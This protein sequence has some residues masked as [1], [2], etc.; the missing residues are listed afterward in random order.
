MLKITVLFTWPKSSIKLYSPWNPF[1]PLSTLF[2]PF[3]SSYFMATAT[4]CNI[5]HFLVM[6]SLIE[7]TCSFCCS[8][9]RQ[10]WRRITPKSSMTHSPGLLRD[11]KVLTSL[12]SN[13]SLSRPFGISRCLKCPYLG[14][15]CCV[16]SRCSIH[17]LFCLLVLWLVS[18]AVGGVS[19]THWVDLDGKMMRQCIFRHGIS[20]LLHMIKKPWQRKF[21]KR[22]NMLT[23]LVHQRQVSVTGNTV[24]CKVELALDAY[25]MIRIKEALFVIACISWFVA[26]RTSFFVQVS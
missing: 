20:P 1:L 2:P 9:P 22:K 26:S 16:T 6:F 15:H 24:R 18:V 3:K 7:E 8:S 13:A 4:T 19:E 14:N 12:S 10:H 25:R 17:R 5:W 21:S 23:F 11:R